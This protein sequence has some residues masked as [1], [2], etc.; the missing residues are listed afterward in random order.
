[1]KIFTI[2]KTGY[3][4]GVYGCTGEYFTLIMINGRNHSSIKFN[5]L[6]G[7]EE[8]VGS[9]L[10][11]KGYKDFYTNGE[12]GRLNTREIHKPTNYSEYELIN[13]G[14]LDK[15]IK[16]LTNKRKVTA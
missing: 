9:Y 3:T 1:M 11:K 8:R 4:A 12:Y 7:A 16:V 6:Y 10:N 14:L 13:G 15:Q 2:I 5:G